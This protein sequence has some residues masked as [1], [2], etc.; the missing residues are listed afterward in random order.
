METLELA[1][2]VKGVSIRD[3]IVHMEVE[4][5]KPFSFKNDQ[6]VRSAISSYIKANYPERKYSTKRS[7]VGQETI[8][9]VTRHK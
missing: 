4:E 3:L 6:T 9:T 2:P 1:R 7:L 5:Q 8:V